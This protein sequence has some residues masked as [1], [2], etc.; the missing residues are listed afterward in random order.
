VILEPQA[1]ADLIGGFGFGF[2]ARNAEEGR[3]VFSAPG[4]K[5]KLGEKVFDDKV[6]IYSDPWNPDLPGSQSAQ[7]GIP[8]QKITMVNKGV[9]ETLTYNRYWAAQK[10]RQ[11]TPGPVNTI[12]QTSGPMHTVEEMIKAT[13]AWYLTEPVLVHSADRPAT[14][15]STGPDA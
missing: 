4:G 10:D 13:P 2:N 14:A 5:T 11:P 15:S 1:V 3:S 7:G 6:T 8:A 12:F 9:L